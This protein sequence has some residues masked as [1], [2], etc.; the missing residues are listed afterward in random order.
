MGASLQENIGL[1]RQNFTTTVEYSWKTKSNHRLNFKLA[2]IE[3]VNNKAINNYFNVYRNSYDRLNQIAQQ[4][5][6]GDSYLNSNGNLG[7]PTQAEALISTVLNGQ[8]SF[9]VADKE[10][11]TISSIQERKDRLTANNFIVGS[12]FTFFEK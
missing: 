12:S 2:D 6:E 3:F 10:Y 8:S 11:V 9:D 7:I 5:P 4:L 1:D